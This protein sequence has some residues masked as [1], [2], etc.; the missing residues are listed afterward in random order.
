MNCA[1]VKGLLSPYVDGLLESSLREEVERH[2]STCPDCSKELASWRSLVEELRSLEK[3]QAPDNFLEGV[4]RRLEGGVSFGK[5][6]HRLLLPEG[7]KLSWG[8]A[9]VVI[10]AFLV[11]TLFRKTQIPS[12]FEY[13]LSTPE[14]PITREM[15]KGTGVTAPGEEVTPQGPSLEMAKPLPLPTSPEEKEK[16]WGVVEVTL[17]TKPV[18]PLLPSVSKAV[19]DRLSGGEKEVAKKER[20]RSNEGIIARVKQAVEG[21]EGN[22]IAEDK[23]APSPSWLLVEVPGDNYRKFVEEL[24]RIGS[25]PKPPT[26]PETRG[27]VKIYLRI[28][29][30]P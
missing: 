14:I 27:R 3:V 10:V 5:W 22:I 4:H 8:L 17:L 16:D 24:S 13:K 28:N 19:S 26:L 30:S 25:V 9:G 29:P 21:V 23:K 11:I 20:G 15:R 1:K 2:L 18:S 7:R 6:L 12:Q